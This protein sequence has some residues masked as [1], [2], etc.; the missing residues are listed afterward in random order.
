MRAKARFLWASAPKGARAE[1]PGRTHGVCGD[2]SDD[3][4][5]IFAEELRRDKAAPAPTAVFF[6]G[7]SGPQMQQYAAAGWKVL[8]TPGFRSDAPINLTE[9][10]AATT[11]EAQIAACTLLSCEAK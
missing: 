11:P 3:I 10:P 5:I 4:P 1:H 7:G 8:A 2:M 6:S 9:V